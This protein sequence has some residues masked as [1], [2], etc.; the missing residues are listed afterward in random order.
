MTPFAGNF[1]PAVLRPN[2]P[3]SS[4]TPSPAKLS[5]P[6]RARALHRHP[7]S[8]FPPQHRRLAVEPFAKPVLPVTGELHAHPAEVLYTGDAPG[9]VSGIFDLSIRIPPNTRSGVAPPRPAS[10]SMS[11]N[12]LPEELFTADLASF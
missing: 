12:N 11:A 9:L 2:S 8:R 1:G 6:I 5:H 4:P 7:Q 3:L 10:L